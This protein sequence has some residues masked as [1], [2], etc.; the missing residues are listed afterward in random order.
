MKPQELPPGM[1]P[2][3]KKSEKPGTPGKGFKFGSP[4]GYILL[5]VLGFLLFRN[6]FQDAGVRRVSYCQFRDAVESGNFSR[7]QISNEWVKGFLKDTA[8][9]PPPAQGERPLRGEP[10][11][12]PWM[13]YRVQGDESLVP[14]LE[15][16]GVQF[17]AVPQ[18]GLGEALWIWLLPLGLF[19]LFWSFMMR[20][21]AGGMGQG[22]QSVMS[23]GKTRAKVQAEADTGV[24]FKDVAGVDEA[25]EELK[26]ID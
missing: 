13:A 1:G 8:Q 10:S 5:L 11:A 7:V 18:S 4:L 23:F 24:G 20:R 17:E 12:L 15:Q 9:P 6:V 19:F 2:R 21:V 3:G 16:K 26:E 22:P 25:V 14:L